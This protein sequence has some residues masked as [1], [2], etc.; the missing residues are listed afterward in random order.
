VFHGIR[1]SQFMLHHMGRETM[2]APVDWDKD[3]WPVV[4]GGK[5]IEKPMTVPTPPN[6]QEKPVDKAWKDCFQGPELDCRWAYLRN[7]VLENYSLGNGLTLRGAAVTLDDCASPTFVGVRQGE[8]CSQVEVSLTVDQLAEGARLGLSVFHVP[9][10]HYDLFVTRREGQ[11]CAVLRRRVVDMVVESAPVALPE[12]QPIQLR[13]DSARLGYTFY[14]GA[15]GQPLAQV[16]TGC[17]QLLST[18]VTICTFTGC[19][20]GMFAEG[21]SQG[22]FQEFTFTP[23]PEEA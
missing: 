7:P 4:N 18:E 8:F 5:P 19:F 3:G 2:I 23:L 14:A 13:I 1:P 16:G 21:A 15:A 9:Q 12:G 20:Y 11:L 17:T 6:Y 10:H 22:T